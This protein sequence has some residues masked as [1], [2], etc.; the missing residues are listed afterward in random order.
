MPTPTGIMRVA[1]SADVVQSTDHG[2]T[3]T[4][5]KDGNLAGIEPA[6]AQRVSSWAPTIV[7]DR[8]GARGHERAG[9]LGIVHGCVGAERVDADPDPV[10]PADCQGGPLSAPAHRSRAR[11]CT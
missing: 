8:R 2:A 3:F 5:V 9:S 6:L 7:R 4:I 1:Y 10:P 11:A